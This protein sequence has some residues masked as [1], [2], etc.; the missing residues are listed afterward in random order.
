MTED[1]M[2]ERLVVGERYLRMK[3]GNEFDRG[4]ITEIGG[5]RK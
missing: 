1:G 2:V 4:I 3:G 5:R